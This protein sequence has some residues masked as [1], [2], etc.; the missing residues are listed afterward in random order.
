MTTNVAKGGLPT[1]LSFGIAAVMVLGFADPSE[2]RRN[3]F[4]TETARAQY[5]ACQNEVKDDRMVMK[6]IC[7]NISDETAREEC[8]EEFDAARE[9]GNQDCKDQRDARRDLCDELGEDRYDP[10][11]DPADFDTDFANPPHPNLYFPL[12][13]GNLWE[14]VAPDETTTIEVLDKTKLI[15]D[16][17][18]VVVNDLVKEKGRVVEDTD[19][20]FAQEKNGSV[21]YCGE[22][23]RDYEFFAGDDPEEAELV[24]I[25]GS[26][27][28]GRDGDK[29]GIILPGAPV[30]GQVFRQEWSPGNAE[31]AA[32]VLSTTYGFGDDPELDEFVPQ[33][34][35]DLLCNDDCVVI[36]EFSPLEPDAFERKYFAPNVGKFLE[37]SPESGKINQLVDCNVD[38]VCDDLPSP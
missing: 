18:C 33:A 8:L 25:D 9:E 24:S 2:G 7:I 26:F 38:D 15:D 30:V 27:K 32:R 37:V 12:T 11:F 6:A 20:W 21:H 35:A 36:A 17:T 3:S 1:Q 34:L 5:V 29:P 10:P 28:A 14:Y 16:V 22:S 4:C 13:I 19:D 31:D 23:V